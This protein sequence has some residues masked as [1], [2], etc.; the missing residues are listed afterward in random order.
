[1]ERLPGVSNYYLGTEAGRWIAGVPQYSAVRFRSLYNGID[2]VYHGARG[3]LEYDF[4]VA[5]GADAGQIALEVEGG[6]GV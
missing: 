3:R 2:L 6:T 4:E 1:L 5:P